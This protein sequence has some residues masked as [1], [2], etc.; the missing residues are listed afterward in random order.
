MTSKGSALANATV[1]PCAP[2][3]PTAPLEGL[4]L[5]GLLAIAGWPAHGLT[6][7]AAGNRVKLNSL[8]QEEEV[9]E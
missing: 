6:A 9:E 5:V 1:L 2:V 3:R 7:T 4:G 8:L